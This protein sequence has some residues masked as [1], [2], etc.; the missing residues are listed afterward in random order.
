LALGVTAAA[1]ATAE[2]ANA[3]LIQLVVN[4]LGDKDKDVRSLGLDQ[5]RNEAKGA[6]ATRQFAAQLSKLTPDAQVGLLSALADRKD[7]AARPAV[8][9]LLG[10]SRDADVRVA[11][12]GALGELGS[13]EDLALLVPLLSDAPQAEQ[14]AARTSLERLRGEQVNPSLAGKVGEGPAAARVALI[15]ILAV[16][17]ARGTLD[18]VLMAAV[19]SD[20]GVRAAAMKALGDLGG[21]QQLPG[22]VQG[23]LKAEKGK[24][25]DAAER[26]VAAVC[27]RG[28]NT[29]KDATALLLIIDKLPPG[30]Q[31]AMLSTLGRVGGASTRAKVEAAIASDD[32]E[33]HALGIRA[34]CNWPDATIAARL[35]ELA[36]NEPHPDHRALALG[37]L[38]R[39]APLR[40]AR[41]AQ[42]RLDLMK[43]AIG[44]CTKDS[45][46][47]T[48]IKRISAI[49]SVE[50]L[51]YL[52][53]FLDQPSLAQQACESIVE[54]AHHRDLREP[55][56]G[57]FHKALDQV[58]TISTDA[59]VKDRAQ[60]YKNNQTWVRPTKDK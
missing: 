6:E 41:P 40:D 57:E 1:P 46:R 10:K 13:A 11:A 28:A 8:V 53:S 9:E 55:N 32:P 30:Q 45:Q 25:R 59:T 49:R 34:L 51:R 56:K 16:R 4:L 12:I 2:D 3:E 37:A 35:M 23:V 58:L 54:L 42:E 50:S 19:D 17:R 36:K 31:P 43:I 14:E 60:R 33:M 21:P 7:P 48:A 29:D 18:T 5:V 52:L 15:E 47:N 22:M 38:I 27:A 20:A 44:M 39:V 24:E 26:A